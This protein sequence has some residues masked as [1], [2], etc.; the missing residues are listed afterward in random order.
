MSSNYKTININ[1]ISINIYRHR[2]DTKWYQTKN[3]LFLDANQVSGVIGKK[4]STILSF[5]R[6][7][8]KRGEPVSHHDIEF[9]I[10]KNELSEVKPITI[11]T[12]TLY[13]LQWA[14]LGNWTAI[15]LCRGII[16][17]PLYKTAEELFDSTDTREKVVRIINKNYDYYCKDDYWLQRMYQ[18][19][20]VS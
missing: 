13:W 11:E 14:V 19:K 7:E 8:E 18:E 16:N 9:L 20:K 10:E 6:A 3:H 1:G 5:I 12:A 2:R 4:F 17:N 15:K